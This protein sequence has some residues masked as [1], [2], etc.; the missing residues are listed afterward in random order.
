MPV[1]IGD[2]VGFYRRK[3]PG[4]G[5]ILEK[6]E[7]ILE[8]CEIDHDVAFQIAENAQGRTY[9]EKKSVIEELCG[10]RPKSPT[11]LKLFFQYNDKWCRKPKISFVR[12]KWFKRPAAYEGRMTEN[13]GWYPA[14]WVRSK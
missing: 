6:I 7:D 4:M 5:I 14:D 10:T 2:L 1:Q 3:T 9:W 12:I 8:Y 11:A 13:E